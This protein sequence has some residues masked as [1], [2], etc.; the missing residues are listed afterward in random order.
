MD[1]EDL[2][3][4]LYPDGDRPRIIGGERMFRSAVLVP[5]VERGGETEILFQLRAP[6]IRQGG[7]V[8]F[9]GGG[10]DPEK[11]SSFQKTVL[12]ETFEE[13]GLPADRVEILGSPGT[14]ISPMNVLVH[15][16]VGRLHIRNT[17]EL[18]LNRDEV[19]RVFTIPLSW[20]ADHAPTEYAVPLRVHP[21]TKDPVTGKRK[22]HFPARRLDLPERYTSPWGIRRSIWSYE[23]DHGVIW[24]MTA[25]ILQDILPLLLNSR[26]PFDT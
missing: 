21:W 26:S 18:T 5:L 24:G 23:T 1:W 25:E 9:P 3:R 12:R 7:E 13:L 17:D 11:D 22:H 8:C 6:H 19:D 4:R 20:F 14:L 15:C 10:F 2:R 16:F